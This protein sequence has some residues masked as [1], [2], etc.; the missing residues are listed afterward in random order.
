MTR[1]RAASSHTLLA[2][3]RAGLVA[4]LIAGLVVGTAFA[5]KGGG[6]PGGGGT[7]SGGTISA[8]R[9]VY[10]QN[11]NGAPNYADQITF[12]FS[13][14]NTKPYITLKCSTSAGLVYSSS[15]LMYTPNIWNDPGIFYLTSPSW[16]G[17]AASCTAYL[18]GT[19][20]SGSTVFLAT[21]G[22]SVGA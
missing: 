15:H 21:Y 10:D 3:V 22:F 12:T 16:Y 18:Y 20:S 4:T 1:I 13:T 7:A 19:T 11:A 9:M 17:G 2:L 14:S 5:A 8:V 6:K